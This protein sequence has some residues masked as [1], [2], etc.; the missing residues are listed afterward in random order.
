MPSVT[1]IKRFSF[2][3][4]ADSAFIYVLLSTS[5][6]PSRDIHFEPVQP[7]NLLLSL[8]YLTA[9]LFNVGSA[10]VPTGNTIEF[11]ELNLLI[12]VPLPNLIYFVDTSRKTSLFSSLPPNKLPLISRCPPVFTLLSGP[13][14]VIFL[15]V[16]SIIISL[17]SSL[18]PNK[19][20]LISRCPPVFTLLSGPPIVILLVDTSINISLFSFIPAIILLSTCISFEN[21]TLPAVIPISPPDP[22][23][24]KYCMES[25]SILVVTSIVF[26]ITTLLL[27]PP[28]VIS[29]LVT[30]VNISLF[31]LLPPNKL[32]LISR[33]PPVTT[34]LVYPPIVIL[35]VDISVKIFLALLFPA[36]I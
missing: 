28:I 14:I 23:S 18:P 24:V 13:P 4:G 12:E 8:L 16:I 9:P 29:L 26:P 30:S 5:A 15:L 21:T 32:P 20:P 2:T 17:F 19:L 10:V 35:F 33:C 25:I 34:V 7:S 6:T 11:D 3:S 22:L 31:S 1:N 27:A 36:D